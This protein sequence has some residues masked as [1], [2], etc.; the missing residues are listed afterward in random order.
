[1][2][3]RNVFLLLFLILSVPAL[4]AAASKIPEIS[5]SLNQEELIN[6]TGKPVI[7]AI[8]PFESKLILV[9][10]N[11]EI[12]RWNPDEKMIDLRL[13]PERPVQAD[14][15]SQGKYLILKAQAPDNNPGTPTSYMIYD[16]SSMKKIA[17]LKKRTIH[18]IIGLNQSLICYVPN[19]EKMQPVIVNYLTGETVKTV[20][21]DEKESVFNGQWQG[22]SLYVLSTKSLHIID[23][24]PANPAIQSIQLKDTAAS[25]FLLDG[26]YIYYG[27]STR[28]LVHFS[29]K[30]HKNKWKFLLGDNLKVEPTKIGKYIIIVAKDNNIYFF[31]KNGTLY[32]WDKLD[33]SLQYAPLPMKDFV[34]VVLWDK[35]I[36]FLDYKHKKSQ[37]FPLERLAV[38]N[39]VCINHYIYIV[40]QEDKEEGAEDPY[41]TYRRL[42]KIGNYYGVEVSNEP[43]GLIP[44]GKSVL[45]SLNPVNLIDPDYE[46]K[47]FTKPAEP[48]SKPELVLDKKLSKKDK[49]T[50]IWI[51]KTEAEHN[52]QILIKSKSHSNVLI[53]KTL[54]PVDI[55]RMIMRQLLDIQGRCGEYNF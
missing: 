38:T 8:I 10:W 31:N 43:Q 47:I 54:T 48:E 19:D 6:L 55:D 17:E 24:N 44:V 28:E 41:T 26:N 35:R 25:G 18:H 39:P 27:S 21:T 32:W 16:L 45:F 50:F 11:G 23:M 40:S 51:P 15:F 3:I 34:A 46:I 52:L 1:M 2:K 7:K 12:F 13:S 49:P 4:F 37:N 36:K 42:A 29:V 30:S 53:E 20:P 33:S 22:N 9:G 5:P 14:C